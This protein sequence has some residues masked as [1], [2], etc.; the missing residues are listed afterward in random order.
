MTK[1]FASLIVSAYNR[2]H[3]L[4]QSLCHLRANTT[5]PYE[6]IVHDDG[7]DRETQERLHGMLLLRDISTL[8]LNPPGYNRGHGT[9]V[10]RAAHMAE[11]DYIVKLNG[12]ECFRP[13]WLEEA[14]AVMERFPEVGLLHLAHYTVPTGKTLDGW[15]WDWP[16][17]DHWTLHRESRDGHALRVVWTGPGCAFMARREAWIPWRSNRDPSFSEDVTFRAA[18]CPMMRLPAWCNSKTHPEPKDLEAHWRAYHATPWLAVLDPPLVSYHWGEGKSL[19]PE[20][21][22]TLHDTPWMVNG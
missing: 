18:V 8:I 2:P 6:L 15:P 22:G 4:N 16:D 17:A 20:A 14:V 1:G 5:Y 7:S 21:R 11:G 12:D 9:S 13:G 10:N 19:M 3:L